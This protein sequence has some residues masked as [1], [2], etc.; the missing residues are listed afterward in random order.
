MSEIIY[1]GWSLASRAYCQC[2]LPSP[3]VFRFCFDGVCAWGAAWGLPG[4]A[5]SV[6]NGVIF[7]FPPDGPELFRVHKGYRWDARTAEIEQ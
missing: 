6:E 7:E 3:D 5:H 4:W 1:M 2:C